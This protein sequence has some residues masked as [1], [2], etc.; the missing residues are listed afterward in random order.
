MK[1]APPPRSPSPASPE[2]HPTT[3]APPA[4]SDGLSSPSE[5]FSPEVLELTAKI[6]ELSQEAL[7]AES[8]QGKLTDLAG[9]P[10]RSPEENVTTQRGRQ[11][12]DVARDVSEGSPLESPV[13]AASPSPVK[14]RPFAVSPEGFEVLADSPGRSRRRIPV[15]GAENGTES[16][17]GTE[18]DDDEHSDKENSAGFQVCL[19]Q[20]A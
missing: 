18:S 20:L 5:A 9:T 3:P 7:L 4:T 19:F 15:G 8:F 12:A 1:T 16:D 13:L 2:S 11:W 10:N 14:I 6:T 17:A